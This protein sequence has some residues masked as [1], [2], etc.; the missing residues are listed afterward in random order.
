ML[1]CFYNYYLRFCCEYISQAL[2]NSS[3]THI[4]LF[5]T[6]VFAMSAGRTM[7]IQAVGRHSVLVH[8]WLRGIFAFSWN[9]AFEASN[10]Q[11]EI[12]REVVFRLRQ[13]I[14]PG[15]TWSA[16]TCLLL[17]TAEILLKLWIEVAVTATRAAWDLTVHGDWC[18]FF[19]GGRTVLAGAWGIC[20][21][22]FFFYRVSTKLN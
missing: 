16:P 1:W 2:N 20:K 12:S 21:W 15:P 10:T 8:N 17:S 6:T 19:I 13:N 4:L 11:I 3:T 5:T 7:G 14:P 22:C 9:V 18:D